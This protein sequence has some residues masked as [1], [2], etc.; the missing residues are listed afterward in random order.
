M[1]YPFSEQRFPI[2]ISYGSSGGP[3]FST[4]ITSTVAGYEQR[5]SHWSEARAV[6][7]VAHGVKTQHQLDQLIAFFRARRGRAQGFRFKDWSDYH[8]TNVTLATAN[9]TTTIFPLVKHYMS[10]T[11]TAIRRIHKPV[12]GTVKIYHN[13]TLQNSG[14]SVNNTTGIITYNN[15]PAN[16]VVISAD[17]EFD[18][19][20]RF[21]T[22]QLIASLDDYGVYSWADIPLVELRI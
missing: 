1:S 7:N 11:D 4:L 15:A 9:G 2:D 14:Y 8:G 18:V 16:G 10:G 20:V 19:P 3:V 22:D 17:Y 21:E 5:T 12:T 13:G 6:Y